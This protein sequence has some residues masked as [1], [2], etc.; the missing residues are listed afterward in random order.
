MSIDHRAVDDLTRDCTELEHHVVDE[1]TAGRLSRRTFLQRGTAIGMSL[2]LLGG[3][4]AACGSANHSSG[5]ASGSTPA[6]SGGHG[7]AGG[8]VRV[9]LVTPTGAIN[10]LTVSDQGGANMLA[11]SGEFL[12]YCN[13]KNVLQP[14]LA[15]SWKP[16]H[17]ATVWTFQ[18]RKGV[19]FNNGKEMT[20]D[21]VV[22]TFKLQCD[23]KNATTALSNF[24]GVLTPDGVK[25]TGTHSVTFHL[26]SANGNFPYLVSSDNYT[27]V[28]F[29]QGTDPTTWQKTFLGTGPFVIRSYTTNSGATFGPNPNWWGG[30]VMP[31]ETQWSFYPTQGPQVLALQNGSVD[32]VDQLVYNGAESVLNSSYNIINLKSSN[33]RELSMRNDQA[34]F[35]DAR[36]RQA[37]ALTLDRPAIISA[38]LHGYGQLGND[39]PFAPVFPSTDQSVPQRHE[40]LAKAR[41]LLAAAGHPSG[42]KTK[43]Y[44]EQLLEV[45]LLAQVIKASAA[46]VG[47]DI[48]LIVQTDSNY[49]GKSTYGQSNWLDGI[50]SLVDYGSRSTPNVFLESALESHGPWNAARF[51]NATYDRLV[52][53]YVAAVDLQ[54]Q[55]Q[56]AGQIQRLLLDETPIVIP[57]Y[58]NQ[59]TVTKRNVGGVFANTEGT[60]FL[61]HATV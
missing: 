17:D 60:V 59:L 29:P 48:D 8:T 21:D 26:E 15:T 53:Q 7:K 6:A 25:K 2:P 12:T 3:L 44:T 19:K 40:D 38:L 35:N 10:P 41:Q 4:L 43:L 31:A 47:I 22:F 57:Y 51:H 27:M 55:R 28:I 5:A 46:K 45:P 14:M 56:L 42:F 33:H 54:T 9:A 49:Y 37:V 30:K 34:P 13:G 11:Q 32:V 24:Q 36:V 39:Y 52:R 18:L 61:Q 58:V 16:N 50:M 23:S 1:F 20:A